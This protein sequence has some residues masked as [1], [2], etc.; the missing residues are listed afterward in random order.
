MT[1]TQRQETLHQLIE[2]VKSKTTHGNFNSKHKININ[3]LG[4]AD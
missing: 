2:I 3:R 1:D 4:T